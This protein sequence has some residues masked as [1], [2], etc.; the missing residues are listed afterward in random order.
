VGANLGVIAH[1]DLVISIF[2]HRMSP[3]QGLVVAFG[4]SVQL[5]RG[6]QESEHD[7]RMI[8]ITFLFVRVLGDVFNSG[9]KLSPGIAT[10]AQCPGAALTPRRS[11][12]NV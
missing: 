11:H 9:W 1:D 8:A 6:Q 4:N 3:P 2:L 12:H 7:R 10:S 5:T